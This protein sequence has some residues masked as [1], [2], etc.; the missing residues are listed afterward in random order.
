MKALELPSDPLAM[1]AV[2]PV[3]VRLQRRNPPELVL[4]IE[5]QVEV[6]EASREMERWKEGE[7]TKVSTAAIERNSREVDRRRQFERGSSFLLPHL[8]V[9]LSPHLKA[10]LH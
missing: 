9:P 4:T 1:R 10:H 3:T 7:G 8:E 6:D 2:K 5:L